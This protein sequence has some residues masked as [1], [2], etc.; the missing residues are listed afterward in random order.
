MAVWKRNAAVPIA[1]SEWTEG[2]PCADRKGAAG[3][4]L[5]SREAMKSAWTLIVAEAVALAAAI[6]DGEPAFPATV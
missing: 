6:A 1:E 3:G 5:S 2:R 4:P